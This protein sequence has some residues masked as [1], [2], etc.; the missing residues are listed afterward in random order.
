MQDH[1]LSYVRYVGEPESL[2]ES[3]RRRRLAR[4]SAPRHDPIGADNSVQDGRQ[5][6]CRPQA[7]SRA[8]MPFSLNCTDIPVHRADG[9]ALFVLTPSVVKVKFSEHWSN[10]Y[11]KYKH[12]QYKNYYVLESSQSIILYYVYLALWILIFFPQFLVKV[13]NFFTL[14]KPRT[15]TK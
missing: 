8:D 11:E 7:A 13:Y 6:A 4:E 5:G 12:L 14:T 15:R 2:P 1:L 9:T 10:I 3:S